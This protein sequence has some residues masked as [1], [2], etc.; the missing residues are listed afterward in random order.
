M[1]LINAMLQ[2]L[3]RRQAL[4]TE[5]AVA[6]VRAS[7]PP[8]KPKREWFWHTL[9][10]LM[11]VSVAWVGWVAFQVMPRPLVTKL[12][13]SLGEPARPQPPAEIVVPAAAAAPVE[14]APIP[15]VES[16]TPAPAPVAPFETLRLATELKS[17]PKL[18]SPPKSAPAKAEPLQ[19]KA[20]AAP[21]APKPTAQGAVDKHDRVPSGSAAA[22]NDFRR[23]LA[24]LNSGRVAEAQQLLTSVLKTEPA[25]ANARQVYVALLVEQGRIEPARR[26][27]EEGLALAPGHASFALT[28]AR[29]HTEQRDY[30]AAL[31][32]LNKVVEPALSEPNHQA[33]RGAVLQRLGRHA[34]AVESYQKALRVAPQQATTWLGLGISLEALNL[35][36]EAGDAYRRALSAGPLAAEA[37]DYAETRAAALR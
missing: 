29:I 15:I 6:A 20:A 14:P 3:D 7:A 4:G 32:V 12:A 35:R 37:R 36:P 10:I 24:L 23:A 28:L 9:A 31:G 33:L 27:L 1:S 16:P 25:H 11:A 17:P 21:A 30:P 22:A 8:A 26:L 19:A 13:L 34:E 2:D 5:P 18:Q